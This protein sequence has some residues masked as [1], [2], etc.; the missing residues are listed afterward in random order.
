MPFKAVVCHAAVVMRPFDVT[1]RGLFGLKFRWWRCRGASLCGLSK[2]T[3]CPFIHDVVRSVVSRIRGSRE[4]P[5]HAHFPLLSLSHTAIC[6]ASQD[7]K[8][9]DLQVGRDS[10][11][12]ACLLASR[13]EMSKCCRFVVHAHRR[14]LREVLLNISTEHKCAKEDSVTVDTGDDRTARA[15]RKFGKNKQQQVSVSSHP[16]NS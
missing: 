12:I 8:E 2:G 13:S 5:R 16:P 6:L 11:C 9:E 4:R 10:R 3:V 15:K 14:N 1:D 7:E